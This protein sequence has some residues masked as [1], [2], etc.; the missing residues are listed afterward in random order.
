[1]PDF[2]V[3]SPLDELV[4]DLG[5]LHYAGIRAVPPCGESLLYLLK[6]LLDRSRQTARGKNPLGSHQM[7]ASK[8]LRSGVRVGAV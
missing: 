3:V 7:P 2:F 4:A 8:V 5:A 6:R 1:M